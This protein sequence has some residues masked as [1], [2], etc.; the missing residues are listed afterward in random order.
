M[1]TP[2]SLFTPSRL[3]AAALAAAGLLAAAPAFAGADEA[4]MWSFMAGSPSTSSAVPADS[5]AGDAR[6]TFQGDGFTTLRQ[7]DHRYLDC[8]PHAGGRLSCKSM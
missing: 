4:H 6:A 3:A 8:V 1:E 7:N 2:M 5:G